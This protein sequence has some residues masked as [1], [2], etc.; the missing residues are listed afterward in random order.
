MQTISVIAVPKITG[1]TN[2][3]ITVTAGIFF[4][5]PAGAPR[6]AQVTNV[7]SPVTISV[8]A[9][10][11][12][13]HRSGGHLSGACYRAI[14][15]RRNAVV[16]RFGYS[17]AIVLQHYDGSCHSDGSIGH[18]LKSG[19]GKNRHRRSAINY[20]EWRRRKSYCSIERR[21][22]S[23]APGDDF[24]FWSSDIRGRLCLRQTAVFSIR[25][26]GEFICRWWR[27]IMSP[28][29]HFRRRLVKGMC[30]WFCGL[31]RYRR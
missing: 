21:G 5:N 8:S 22:Q 3:R 30:R 17:A 10:F 28:W 20:S 14:N 19:G 25:S 13:R 6:I 2:N 15:R 12:P 27:R 23:P 26:S 9:T 16:S 4:N 1:V 11:N 7:A 18:S 31:W 24:G 29:E